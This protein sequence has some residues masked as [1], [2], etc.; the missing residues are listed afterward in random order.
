[1]IIYKNK[2]HSQSTNSQWDDDEQQYQLVPLI[3][4]RSRHIAFN[5]LHWSTVRPTVATAAASAAAQRTFGIDTFLSRSHQ[6]HFGSKKG[7]RVAKVLL[8]TAY[9]V[10]VVPFFG[11]VPESVGRV[12]TTILNQSNY[13]YNNHHHLN[14]VFMR[15]CMQFNESAARVKLSHGN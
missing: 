6:L 8:T 7:E 5:V 2:T 14:C 15:L 11:T 10:P 9:F 1:M 4:V 12:G 13:N 3:R